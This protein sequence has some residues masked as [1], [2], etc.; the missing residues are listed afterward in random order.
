MDD[1]FFLYESKDLK[2]SREE[3]LDTQDIEINVTNKTQLSMKFSS[4]E[5][6][7]D[8]VSD[9]D[10]TKSHVKFVFKHNRNILL[11]SLK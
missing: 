5:L 10:I 7:F 11:S 8:K 2:L 1:A 4:Q 6:I 3:I 9:K